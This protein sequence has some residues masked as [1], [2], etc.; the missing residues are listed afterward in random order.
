MRSKNIPFLPYPPK[1][2]RAL[3]YVVPIC[4]A[5]IVNMVSNKLNSSAFCRLFPV[6]VNDVSRGSSV[7]PL[8]MTFTFQK[9][10]CNECWYWCEGKDISFLSYSPH[11]VE[12]RLASL[13]N[14]LMRLTR[15]LKTNKNIQIFNLV[16]NIFFKSISGHFISCQGF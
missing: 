8:S 2:T 12:P 16:L 3:F 15:L 10:R 6:P 14:R 9:H 5:K 13:R 11:K 7:L 1:Y 4:I